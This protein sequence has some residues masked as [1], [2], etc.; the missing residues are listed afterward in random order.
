M[1]KEKGIE[2][3]DPKMLNPLKKIQEIKKEAVLLFGDNYFLATEAALEIC[4][5]YKINTE[6]TQNACFIC[7]LVFEVLSTYPPR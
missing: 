3:V 5:K 4:E 7:R 1:A 6:N 2:L